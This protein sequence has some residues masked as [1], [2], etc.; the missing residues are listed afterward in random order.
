MS[1]TEIPEIGE[2]F[3]QSQPKKHQNEVNGVV[4]VFFLLALNIFHFFSSVSFVDFAQVNVSWE[5][6]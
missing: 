5:V 6:A 3:V 2:K 4:L 1:I